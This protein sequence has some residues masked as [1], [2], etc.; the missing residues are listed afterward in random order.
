MTITD[1]NELTFMQKIICV[2]F[3]IQTYLEMKL[4]VVSL[5]RREEYLLLK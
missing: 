2:E 4:C 1:L 5:S 3:F